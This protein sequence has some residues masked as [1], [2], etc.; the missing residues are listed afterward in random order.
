MFGLMR[1]AARLPYCGTC[2]SLG[3]L[4][5]QR[6]RVLL[7]HDIVFLAEL[8]LEYAGE[9]QWDYAYRS[10]NCFSL[11]K[12]GTDLPPALEYA[13][14]AT[15]LLAHFNILDQ[16]AD[17]R[18]ARWQVA[19]AVFSSSYRR[20]RARLKSWQFPIEQLEAALGTQGT[21]E[22]KAQSFE[23]VSEP[24]AIA[25]ALVFSHGARVA[26][27]TDLMDAMYQIGHRFG[28]LVYLLDAVEDCE[29]DR[30]TGDFNPLLAFPELRGREEIVSL[31]AQL[32]PL[33]P[34][35]LAVRLRRNAEERLGLRLRVLKHRC[36]KTGRERWRDAKACALS[37]RDR[38]HG[39][40]VKGVLVFASVAVIAFLFP[41][42]ARGAESWR[43]CLGL[44]FNL[45]AIAGTFGSLVPPTPPEGSQPV[46]P[47]G[48]KSSH[49][50]GWGR[51]C[52]DACCNAFCESG[53]ECCSCCDCGSCHCC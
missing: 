34:A 16:Q 11:P 41:H 10:Y 40:V 3:T 15:V 45:M 13:A 33:L 8:L 2:K 4:Y 32:E 29:R 14:T 48:R 7:N 47:G 53:G 23:E 49:S 1:R 27:R 43:Q 24:T 22:A 18:K 38:E 30:K 9:P 50:E 31:T 37:L 20:A 21:R 25:T 46:S 39:G 28:T 6:T 44:G 5:G 51:C 52:C 36:H 17:T 26:G 12:A 42:Q 19:A 35:P